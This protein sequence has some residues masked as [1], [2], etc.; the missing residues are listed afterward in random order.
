MKFSMTL[1][2][3]ALFSAVA[4]ADSVPWERLNKNDSML[5]VVDMQEGLFNLARDFDP[6]LY[7]NAMLAHSSLAKVFDLPVVLTTS[8]EYGPNGPLPQEI[9]DDHPTAPLIKRNGEVDA[10]DNSDF[11]DAVRAANKTQIILAGI[12][13]DVCT[14]FLALSLRAEGYSVWA[15]VEASGTTTELIRD[16]SN[17][18]MA[19]AGVQVVSLFSIALD[20]MRDWRNTPGAVQL[21]SWLDVYYPAY[22]YIARGHRAAVT[23]GTIID[24]ENTLPL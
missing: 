24:G 9:L 2:V 13:T 8:A 5:L 20:L 6:T 11:R 14:T 22:G 23:N 16:I 12:T 1:A 17:D 10:W 7:R 3:S 18:R 15:N 4:S 19:A 21:L